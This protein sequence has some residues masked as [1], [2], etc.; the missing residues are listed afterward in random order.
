LRGA[1]RALRHDGDSKRCGTG[2]ARC[3]KKE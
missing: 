1:R 2:G 3:A